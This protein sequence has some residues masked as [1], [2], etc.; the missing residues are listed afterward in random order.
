[1][2]LQPVLN[3]VLEDYVLPL[4][5]DHGVAH[6]ARVPENGLRLAESTGANV[7][8][9]SHGCDAVH[10]HLG[11]Y[12][13]RTL[14]DTQRAFG[15]NRLYPSRTLAEGRWFGKAVANGAPLLAF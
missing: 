8:V 6:W 9:V 7:D 14:S 11:R 12:R 3:A 15:G 4:G 2:N 10:G 13:G 1:M 5:G